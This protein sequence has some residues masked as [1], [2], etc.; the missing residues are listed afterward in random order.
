MTEDNKI[1]TDGPMGL[2]LQNQQ[3]QQRVKELEEGK[4]SAAT[5]INRKVD[6]VL[7]LRSQLSTAQQK[8]LEA[9]VREATLQ[10][11]LSKVGPCLSGDRPLDELDRVISLAERTM[12]AVEPSPI[13]EALEFYADENNWKV[14]SATLPIRVCVDVGKIAR[15]ALGKEVTE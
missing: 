7:D 6:Q 9:E 13:L 8:L 11:V 12:E 4:D 15:Q 2:M 3:L 14:T 5:I 10:L 1:E